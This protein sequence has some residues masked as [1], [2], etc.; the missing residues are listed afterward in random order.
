MPPELISDKH[1]IQSEHHLTPQKK[2][3]YFSKS[4]T[5]L[6]DCVSITLY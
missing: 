4:V 5:L 3:D 6:T 2:W 1:R